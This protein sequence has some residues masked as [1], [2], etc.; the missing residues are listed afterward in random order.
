MSNHPGKNPHN[1]R[2]GAQNKAQGGILEKFIDAS[3]IHYR[4]CGLAE[5]EKTPEPFK[6]TRRVSEYEFHG[7]FEKQAQPDYKGALHGGRAIVFEAK[8]SESDRIL[9]NR[10][11]EMQTA[12]LNRYQKL[13]AR[14]FVLVS[15][16]FQVFAF[17]PWEHWLEMKQR[18]KHLHMTESDLQQYRVPFN[19]RIITFL[20]GVV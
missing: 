3:C 6:V 10:V 13:G 5:I 17:V 15:L 14:C 12:T 9:K 4:D 18:F 11:T 19:G 16:R 20:K 8:H 7:H 2:R 1:Q